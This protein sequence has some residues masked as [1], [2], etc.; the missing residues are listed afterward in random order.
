MCGT[1]IAGFLQQ[2]L[3]RG[4]GI[5]FARRNPP[6]QFVQ[7]RDVALVAQN[8]VQD[9]G[10]HHFQQAIALGRCGTSGVS[11]G[12][13]KKLPARLDLLD[14]FFDS[15]VLGSHRLDDAG[16]PAILPSGEL[17]VALQ[18]GFDSLHARVVRL[19]DDED[20]TDLHDACFHG[21]HIVAHA[22]NQ[23]DDVTCAVRAMS[24]S[25]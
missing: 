8:R 16:F 5:D 13:P 15:P 12:G 3:R 18:I 20:I 21:L 23:Q 6:S 14:T 10:A 1:R 9:A 22:R 4:I 25:S 17:K 7:F 2:F 11:P 19:V 24:T